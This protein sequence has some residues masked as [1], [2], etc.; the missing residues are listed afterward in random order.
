MAFDKGDIVLLMAIN[1]KD[2]K[3]RVECKST[4]AASLSVKKDWLDK[5]LSEAVASGELPVFMMSFVDATGGARDANSDW[6]AF[7]K[8]VLIEL[9]GGAD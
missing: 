1:G 2:Y 8:H 6:V 5:I 9:L 3:G 7:P 4:T